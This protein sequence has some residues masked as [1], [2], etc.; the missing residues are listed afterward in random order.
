MRILAALA[1]VTAALAAPTA[2]WAYGSEVSAY[3]C[4]TSGGQVTRL[5]GTEIVVRQGWAATTK[6]YDLT[7]HAQQTFASGQRRR[8]RSIS[9]T[10]GQRRGRTA[11]TTG[12]RTSLYP[13]DRARSGS[14]HDLPLHDQPQA[15][16][17][18]RSQRRRAGNRHREQLHGHGPESE[19]AEPAVAAS[20]RKWQPPPP[21]A[22]ACLAS[23][24]G[25]GVARYDG[26]AGVVPKAF[27]PSMPP[28]ELD[29][30]ER[31]LGRRSMGV[32]STSA[33]GPVWRR[34]RW[35]SSAGRR[36]AST[37]P[38]TCSRPPAAAVSRSSTDPRTELPSTTRNFRCRACP[39]QTHIDIDDFAAAMSETARVLRPEAPVV[40]IGTH[41]CFM[42]PHSVF[43]GWPEAC[44][45]C[46]AATVQAGRYDEFGSQASPTPTGSV[47][48]VGSRAS[49]RSHAF[50][51]THSCDA[52][53]PDSSGSRSSAAGD[54]PH[55][56]ALRAR[57]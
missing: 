26:V 37:S 14:E 50:L 10:T 41:P 9:P 49:V 32:V 43:L 40:Y 23:I 57:R 3:G 6:H 18:R 53:V 56:M 45:S 25:M 27:R 7:I 38:R 15:V 4:Y 17:L 51:A 33:A 36:W 52:G 34:K 48:C 16:G 54:Y 11:R 35:Q 30:P 31:L 24:G 47:R 5:A 2:A 13:T 1:L 28:D 46:T 42:G 29:V 19:R 20:D 39:S 12:S 44:R 21:G 8:T 22:A 55:V